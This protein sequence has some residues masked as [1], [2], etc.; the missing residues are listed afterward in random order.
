MRNALPSRCLVTAIAATLAGLGP[1][2][3]A[4]EPEPASL[5]Y[6][7]KAAFLFQFARFVEWP[8][9]ASGSA[10]Q[11][12]ICVVGRDPFGA[13]LERAIAGKTVDGKPL[14]TRAFRGADDV[15]PCPILY[16]NPED[17]RQV[18]AILGRLGRAPS[19]TVGEG[20]DFVEAGGMVGFFVEDNRVRFAVNL[21]AAARG[22][23][24]LSSRL[25]SVAMLIR[26][27][28]AGSSR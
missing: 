23:L 10:A 19:L 8:E 15:R 20:R 16:V 5:E 11:F 22:D 24:R 18:P 2:A 27:E 28:P 25:L 6:P 1:A 14:V 26:I 21:G 4:G 9:Q 13:A 12:E 3:R 7:V 17:P